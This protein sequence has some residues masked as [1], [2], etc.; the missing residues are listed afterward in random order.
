[1]KVSL[2]E[3]PSFTTNLLKKSI[4]YLQPSILHYQR[5]KSPFSGGGGA[6]IQKQVTATNGPETTPMLLIF[7]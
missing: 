5:P 4:I 2:Q 7:E 6:S 3:K 1:M